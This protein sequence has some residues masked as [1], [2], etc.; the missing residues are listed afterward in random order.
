MSR[1]NN[2]VVLITGGSAGLGLQLAKSC[3]AQGAIVILV[4]RDHDRLNV[5]KAEVEKHRPEPIL[6]SQ[7]VLTYA[8]DITSDEQVSRLAEWVGTE[9]GTLDVLVNVAGKSDRGRA[10]M[11]PVA[12]YAELLELNFLATV[13]CTQMLLPMI[14]AS[15]GSIVNIGSLASKTA[16]GFLGAYPSSKFPVAAFS[17]QLRLELAEEGVHILLVC[18]G[19]IAR[20]D[21]GTRYD[22]QSS[23]LPESARKPGGG[24]KVKALSPIELSQRIMS[25]CERRSPEL[26]IPG[27]ARILFAIQQLFPRLGD[28][29]CRKMTGN[30]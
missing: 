6:R 17:Q 16:S 4:A 26:V 5:A 25:A 14:K 23:D 22:D 2:K 27:K 29:L 19:P 24:A 30:S 8:A 1:W 13:R 18:P 15:Q 7:R 20:E 3:Y 10:D 11:V 21:A 12:R 9:I 28:W